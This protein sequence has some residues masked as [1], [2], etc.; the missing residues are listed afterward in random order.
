MPPLRLKFSTGTNIRLE[1]L[2]EGA[3]KSERVDLDFGEAPG[4]SFNLFQHNLHNDDFEVS[5]M[6][7]SES[8][9]VRE[10]RD[11][12]GNGRWHWAYIPVFLGRG[13]NWD[14]MSVLP[15]SSIKSA[16]DLK[17][18]K[19]AV[20]DYSMTSMVWFRAM[21]KDLFGIETS[22]ISWFNLR[23]RGKETGL[24]RQPPRGVE[25]T[26][27]PKDADPIA[28]L[29]KGEIDAVHGLSAGVFNSGKVRPL[30][31]NGA[32]EL[33]LQHYRMTGA[34]HINHHFIIQQSIL[35]QNPGVAMAIY[36]ALE[37]SR[38]V[39]VERARKWA[40]AYLYFDGRD[41][42]EQDEIFGP[43]PYP[44]GVAANRPTIERLIQG[45][46]EQGLI[47]KRP[48]VEEFYAAETL[49]T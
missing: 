4:G 27:L 25:I 34:H 19:V 43:E 42:E 40:P 13:L 44:S 45:S 48:T 3:V 37:R 15:G 32:K 23:D 39:A 9:I 8:L 46:Y 35:D 30:F 17:G 2:R 47:S 28:L 12:F 49:A 6:S 1:P 18:K 24:D 36:D 31:P 21:L 29:E 5:E 33:A 20:G 38:Q 16:A 10:R 7:M 22:D 11:T 14:R 26:W 41:F